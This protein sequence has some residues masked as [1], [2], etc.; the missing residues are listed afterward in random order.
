MK[1]K[2]LNILE[3]NFGLFAYFSYFLIVFFLIAHDGFTTIY[4][5]DG[6]KLTLNSNINE[7]IA[8]FGASDAGTYAKC[9]LV[10]FNGDSMYGAGCLPLF[11]PGMFVLYYLILNLGGI[12]AGIYLWFALV[13][14][15]IWAAVFYLMFTSIEIYLK[16]IFSYLMPITFIFVPFAKDYFWNAN[17]LMSESISIGLFIA[18]QLY[19]FLSIAKGR[20]R[21]VILYGFLIG[22]ASLFRAQIYLV[23]LIQASVIISIYTLIKIIK[24]PGSL[25]S[26]FST[27]FSRLKSIILGIVFASLVIVPYLIWN[28]S[29]VG[30]FRLFN[31]DYYFKY[32]WMNDAD[33]TPVQS[34]ILTG[35]GNLACRV[36][37]TQ[38]L[39]FENERLKSGQDSISSARYKSAFIKTLISNPIT[40]FIEKLRIAPP[41]WFSSPSATIPAGS[42]KSSFGYIM[43]LQIAFGLIFLIFR[44]RDFT[45]PDVFAINFIYLTSLVSNSVVFMGTHFEVRY[46]YLLF[47]T[48]FFV[49]LLQCSFLVNFIKNFINS[50]SQKYIT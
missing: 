33:Y 12:N 23:F 7:I 49:F 36:N 48:I 26:Y 19:L 37:P 13:N 17:L 8:A 43:L 18:S 50:K 9:G 6:I 38:C 3:N 46:F 40:F 14:S 42:S 30:E 4:D 34:W 2:I 35:G 21:Y 15:V 31:A 11:P 45:K 25:S 44:F 16:R 1:N 22:I 29:A 27:I 28:K 32:P 5:V 24:L 47:T 20:Q 41:Y 39:N 10:M